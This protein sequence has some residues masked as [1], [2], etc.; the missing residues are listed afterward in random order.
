MKQ[1]AITRAMNG[2]IIGMLLYKRRK[3][4]LNSKAPFLQL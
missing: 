4:P 2:M 1:R 3:M